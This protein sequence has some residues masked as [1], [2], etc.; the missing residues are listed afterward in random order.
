[1]SEQTIQSQD[2]NLT[3]VFQA[4]YTVPDYQREYVWE[5]ADVEQ[6]LGDINGELADNDA[7]DAPEYFIGSI[8]VCP[9][10]NGVLEKAKLS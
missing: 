8:V 3:Q 5:T 7:A 6:F 2:I 10:D 4:F 1:M 9:G